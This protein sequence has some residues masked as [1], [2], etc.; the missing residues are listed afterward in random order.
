MASGS[1]TSCRPRPGRRGQSWS[2]CPRK[3]LTSQRDVLALSSSW[4]KAPTGE[5]AAGA[6]R[7]DHGRQDHGR[8]GK[9]ELSQVGT[10]L[11]LA[12]EARRFWSWIDGELFVPEHW[13]AP[14]RATLR[15]RWGHPQDRRF[16]TKIELGC[17]SACARRACPL[18]RCAVMSCMGAVGGCAPSWTR[19]VGSMGPR[20]PLIRQCTWR[21]RTSVCLPKLR[22]PRAAEAR[23]RASWMTRHP[24]QPP[25]W[26]ACPT[27]T[28]SSCRCAKPN[29]ACWPMRLPCGT[30]APCDRASSPRSGWASVG[31]SGRRGRW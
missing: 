8:L 29:A 4:R 5:P 25:K 26:R 16:A 10:F 31:S 24:C 30:S 28:S 20:S 18:R 17:S 22:V 21:H 12:N 1:S 15:Q 23:R 3:L 2:R 19:P 14:E 27:P 13:F 7:Q 9:V 11:A 6:G